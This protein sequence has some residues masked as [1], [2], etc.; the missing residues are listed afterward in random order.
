MTPFENGVTFRIPTDRRTASRLALNRGDRER[1]AAN[2]FAASPRGELRSVGRS[3][4]QAVT[5]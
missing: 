2:E 5:S 1:G 4:A 3:P